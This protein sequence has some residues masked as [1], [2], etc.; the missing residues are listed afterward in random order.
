VSTT[1]IA[2]LPPD[3]RIKYVTAFANA[4][5]DT[6]LWTVPALVIAV[7]I[8]LTLRQIPMRQDV[9]AGESEPSLSETEAR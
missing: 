9:H 7:L 3:I 2:H 6:Y 4:L 8:A 1:A 5:T